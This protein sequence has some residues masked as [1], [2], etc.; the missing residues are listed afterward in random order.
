MADAILG[1]GK[2][3]RKSQS[4]AI[5]T[6]DLPENWVDLPGLVKDVLV[7]ADVQVRVLER[8]DETGSATLGEL[9]ALVPDHPQPAT[10]VLRL[11][12]RGVLTIEPGLI[13]AESLLYRALDRSQARDK[14]DGGAGNNPEM[15]GGGKVHR[16]QAARP[17]PEIF[18]A[19]WSDRS[20]FRQEPALRGP[21][22]YLA[23]YCNSA[24]SGSSR[25]LVNRMIASNHLLQHGVP[26][27]IIAA[28]DRNKILTD[29]QFL[30]CERL[31]AR[32]V[33]KDPVLDLANPVL[34]A[35]A[36]VAPTQFAQADRFVREFVAALRE[37]GLAFT[38]RAA[39]AKPPLEEAAEDLEAEALDAAETVQ[40]YSMKACGVHATARVGNGK[41]VV[42][43]GSEV[44]S[45]VLASAGSGVVQ[46]RQEL[47]H[48]GGLM[49][50]GDHL[51]LTRDVAFETASSAAR[52][53]SG[54]GHSARVWHPIPT[55]P[56]APGLLH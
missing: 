11:A 10:A 25:F 13:D 52:F 49:A 5:P 44:R 7:N 19:N 8:I 18:F 33:E 36:H 30:V 46:Q 14:G 43:T 41:W 34:P 23:L 3:A 21:G 24:Y 45:D 17:Q 37:A 27:L 42:Q 47:L 9:M 35:G 31:L 2:H 12:E 22:F 26:D 38:G 29:A 39:P 15:S 32:A 53:V 4:H 56:A 20:V 16:L 1:L 51:L 54:S 40:H 50:H 28:V 55:A 6:T 48:D